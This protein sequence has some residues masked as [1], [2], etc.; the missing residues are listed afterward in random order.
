MVNWSNFGEYDLIC[1]FSYNP[2]IPHRR[3]GLVVDLYA[4]VC[5]LKKIIRFNTNYVIQI[6]MKSPPLK[7]VMFSHE[8]R[9][10]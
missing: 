2:L 8:I 7:I 5:F 9:L 6:H 3:L 10:D 1:F 4:Y